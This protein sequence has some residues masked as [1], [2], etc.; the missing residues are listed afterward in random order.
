MKLINNLVLSLILVSAAHAQ[1]LA[2]SVETAITLGPL[3]DAFAN[4]P[5]ALA[6]LRMTRESDVWNRGEKSVDYFFVYKNLDPTRDLITTVQVNLMIAR[7][8][9]LGGRQLDSGIHR[10]RI[11]AGGTF[12]LYGTL[13]WTDVF[14]GMVLRVDKPDPA[15]HPELIQRCIFADQPASGTAA[16]PESA[17]VSEL[18]SLKSAEAI[19]G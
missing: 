17:P 1:A 8:G 3:A 13:R 9:S 11:P 5:E 10:V 4:D 15:A 16:A 19:D 14:E 6:M 2:P 12:V 7:P 18:V